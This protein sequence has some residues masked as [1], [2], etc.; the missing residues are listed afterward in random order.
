[1]IPFNVSL[2]LLNSFQTPLKFIA[3]HKVKTLS[4]LLVPERILQFVAV[5]LVNI[6]F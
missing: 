5:Y 2:Y 3:Y 1:V 6:A 4:I